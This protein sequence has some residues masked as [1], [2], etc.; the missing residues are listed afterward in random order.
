MVAHR[1]GSSFFLASTP[2]VQKCE[3]PAELPL[4]CCNCFSCISPGS[5]YAAHPNPRPYFHATSPLC[6]H[7][8]VHTCCA[9]CPCARAFALF[10]LPR[11]PRPRSTF[12]FDTLYLLNGGD[13]G[14]DDGTAALRIHPAFF[15]NYNIHHYPT[16]PTLHPH[17]YPPPPPTPH[18][19]LPSR[20]H[21]H[22][23]KSPHLRPSK[24][25]RSRPITPPG[26]R[27]I[28]PSSPHDISFDMPNTFSPT[29]YPFL[30]AFRPILFHQHILH[31]F[32]HPPTP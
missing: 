12:F 11:A 29:F 5:R 28:A 18:S 25:T 21:H 27:V 7:T 2:A 20:L 1:T 26:S 22:T 4:H 10:T 32:L 3:T 6:P 30:P 14:L 17:K 16:P 9:A 8:P 23:P 31:R 13:T 24:R 19:P 15:S